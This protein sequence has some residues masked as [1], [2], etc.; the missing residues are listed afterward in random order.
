MAINIG[1]I[2]NKITEDGRTYLASGSELVA[3][4]LALLLNFPKY[5]LFFGNNM[6][7]DLEKYLH[8]KNKQAIFN[9]IKADI[10]KLFDKYGKVY[11]KKVDMIFGQDSVL[12]ITLTVSMDIQGRETFMIPLT[13]SN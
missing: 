4:E 11:L 13:V 6:G 1:T 9:L 7:L 3:G 12:H 10:E 5:S 2:Y 8:L